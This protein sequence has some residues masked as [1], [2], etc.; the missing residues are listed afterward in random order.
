MNCRLADKSAFGFKMIAKMGWSE[1]KGLGKKEDGM[2]THVR[3]KRRSD[4]TGAQGTQ[5]QA[6]VVTRPDA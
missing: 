4:Q 5:L 1:G 6:E 2:A 3:V